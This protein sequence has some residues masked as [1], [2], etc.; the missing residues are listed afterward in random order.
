MRLQDRIDGDTYAGLG[1]HVTM[2]ALTTAAPTY[3]MEVGD[4]IVIATSAAADAAGIVTLP[5][6]A[7]ATG[8]MYYVI[9]PTGASGGDISLTVK[10][11]ATELT[12]YGDLDADNDY[13][14]LFSDGTN[15]RVVTNGVA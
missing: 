2:V 6:V 15:W 4:H 11:N 1:N 5:S 12:T 7:E 9:A 8:M 3:D 13:V 10:E 14:I